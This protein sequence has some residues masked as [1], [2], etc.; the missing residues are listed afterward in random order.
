M[1]K[2]EVRGQTSFGSDMKDDDLHKTLFCFCEYIL[3]KLHWKLGQNFNRVFDYNLVVSLHM[4][5]LQFVFIQM[6]AKTSQIHAYK[7]GLISHAK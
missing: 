3:S 5:N 4:S 7:S 2:D 1:T 6:N